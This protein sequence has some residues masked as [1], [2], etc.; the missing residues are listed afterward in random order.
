MSANNKFNNTTVNSVASAKAELDTGLVAEHYS[1][2]EPYLIVILSQL[3]SHAISFRVEGIFIVN[4]QPAPTC[5]ESRQNC[6]HVYI[7]DVYWPLRHTKVPCRTQSTNFQTNEILETPKLKM[8]ETCLTKT[9]A[10]I[11]VMTFTPHHYLETSNQTK[12]TKLKDENPTKIFP[13]M[14]IL[15]TPITT[16]T[17]IHQTQFM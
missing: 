4:L 3:W 1:Y 2:P 7:H 5:D 6:W 9:D 13:P 10:S 14:R 15:P 17:L 11:P 16:L 8:H 12:S